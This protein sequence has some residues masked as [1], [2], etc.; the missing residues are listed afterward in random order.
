MDVVAAVQL[1]DRGRAVEQGVVLGRNAEEAAI[2]AYGLA[3][4]LDYE[5]RRAAR[6][7]PG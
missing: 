4:A 6:N 2:K 5:S 7:S 1:H 3:L